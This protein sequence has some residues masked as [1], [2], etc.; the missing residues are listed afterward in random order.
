MYHYFYDASKGEVG[1]NSNYIEIR[2]FEEQVKY[3]AD[4]NYYFPTWKEVRD[5]VEG[6]IDLPEKSVVLTSDDG[7]WSFFSEAIPI[8][9]KYNA[10][11]TSFIVTSGVVDKSFLYN[12]RNNINY[13]LHTHNMHRGGCSGGANG[14][15][16]CIS[17]EEGL[18]DLLTSFS[19]LE[20]SEALAY[21]YGD[22]NDNVLKIATDSH[23]LIGVTTKQGRA[24]KG[25]DPLRLPRMRIYQGMSL[26]NFIN[27][28]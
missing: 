22:C 5:F 15:F 16:R 2:D 9:E 4:N 28:L 26:K 13:Q 11:M 14:L 25:M 8:V 24:K 10:K 18:N 3:L 6:K 12:N 20:S 23:V 19:V 17:Y 1:P 7:H 27:S 21:L